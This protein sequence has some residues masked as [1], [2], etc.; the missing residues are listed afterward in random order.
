MA[1][2]S[3]RSSLITT[4]A[5][6]ALALA[7][8]VGGID[9]SGAVRVDTEAP[10]TLPVSE[11][12]VAAEGVLLEQGFTVDIDCGPGEVPFEIGTSV[13][14]T[15]FE[16]SSGDSGGFTV[17][18]TS[19]E[20]TDYQ[21][22]VVGSE[23]GGSDDG[24]TD[25]STVEPIDAFTGFVVD[26]LTPSLGEVPV[27]DCGSDDVE[28]FAGQEVLCF[29]ETSAANAYILVTVTEFDGTAYSISIDEQ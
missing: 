7:G 15:G 19:I 5:V 27:V 14:C 23:A 13:E 16:P 24:G 26:V 8:C 9:T 29:Y 22:E 1:R 4:L 10:T 25:Q 20:G 17:T 2:P 28:I 3:L 11:L 12:A 21:V 18:I 6:G